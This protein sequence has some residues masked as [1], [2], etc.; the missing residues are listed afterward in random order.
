MYMYRPIS[1]AVLD[2]ALGFVHVGTVRYDV[3]IGRCVEVAQILAAL[4]RP[5]VVNHGNRHVT[6][7]LV[8]I[9]KGVEQW[10]AYGHEKEEYDYT[11]VANDGAQLLTKYVVEI[12]KSLS[13]VVHDK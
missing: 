11:L 8:G 13:P 2:E 12:G 4:C 10:V 3:H 7:H 1:V 9:N 5:A 6:H